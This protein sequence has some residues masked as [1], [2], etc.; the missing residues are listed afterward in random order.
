MAAVTVAMISACSSTKFVPEDRYLLDKVVVE[1][2]DENF[3]AKE[4]A[5]Y[6]RQ[7]T[8]SKW[9]SMLRIPLATY[10]LAGRDSAKWI[11]R[12]LRHLG[13]PPVLYDSLQAMLS[14]NDLKVALQNRGY[15]SSYVTHRTVIKGKKLTDIYTL[16][17]GKPY[18]IGRVDYD[19]QDSTIQRILAA[20]ES[21][22]WTIKPGNMFTVNGLD[23]E[24]KR[25]TALLTDNGYYRFNKEF[26]QFTADTVRNGYNV[27]LTLQLLKY[28]ENN[29]AQPRPHQVYHIRKVNFLSNTD[30]P[31]RLRHAVLENASELQAGDLYHAPAIQKTYN[32]FARLSA[33]KYTNIRLRELED[34]TLLDCDI[35][36][37]THKPHTLSFSPEG[38]NTAGDLGAAATL[39]YQNRNL[40]H[41]S[42]LLT[43]QFRG[44][45]EAITGLEGYSNENYIEYGTEAKLQFPTF[46]APFLSKRFLRQN[47]ATSELSL[48][49]NLQNRPEFH[50][51]LF[52]AAWRY[53]WL[54]K[55]RNINYKLD[56]IDLNYIYMPWISATFKQNYLDDSSTTRNA[57]LRYNYEDLFIMRIGFG[58]SYTIGSHAVRANIET[59]G[60]VLNATS[61]LFD[62]KKNSEGQYTL[63]NIAFA[64][65]VKGD[66][67]YTKAFAF[68]EHNSLIFHAGIGIAYPYGNSRVLPFEKRYFSG[69]SNSVRGWG[70]RRLGPGKYKGHEGAID[71]INQTGDMRLDLNMEFRTFLFWKINGALFIDA[72]NIWTLRDYQEQPGGQFKFSEFYKQIAVSYGLGFRLNFDYFILRFDMGMKAVNPAYETSKEHYPLLHPKL[73]RDFAFHFAVGL[74]F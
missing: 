15:M 67:D 39:S 10:S 5:P 73:S 57:I 30:E 48:G 65:Y 24:R 45:F 17:P 66:F 11:N 31:L 18:Y 59:A 62:A 51:R 46:V 29:S 53:R 21:S 19:I 22:S 1:S 32:N 71:F 41:G 63:F 44:A 43:L 36:I 38:T 7:K 8:N 72:G 49:Y 70:V 54:D 3:D 33:V 25:I 26:I 14:M 35:V 2:A 42:E 13:E 37:G 4:L 40:F 56:L 12:S 58:F 47:Y 23:A 61:S 50:R 20:Q 16:H 27:D 68:D 34:T 60:N 9:F 64:Q 52:S 69:G 6:V 28:K 55:G 74:P